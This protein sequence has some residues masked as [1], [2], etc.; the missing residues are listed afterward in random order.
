[1]ACY[2]QVGEGAKQSLAGWFAGDDEDELRA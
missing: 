1:M 2:F